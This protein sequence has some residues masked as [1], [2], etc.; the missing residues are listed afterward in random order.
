MSASDAISNHQQGRLLFSGCDL[1]IP[2]QVRQ[3]QRLRWLHFDQHAIQACIDLDH[4]HQ[5][6]IP[7]AEA[8]VLAAALKPGANRLLNLGCG[9]GS[10][11]RYFQHYLPS[12]QITS[13][14]A[15]RLIIDLAQRWFQLPDDLELF[16]T[17]AETFLRQNR[18][19]FELI[20]CDLHIGEGHADCLDQAEF[21]RQLKHAMAPGGILVCNLLP[22]DNDQLLR[23]LLPLR[24]AFPHLL[25]L[26][27]ENKHNC[28]IFG[29]DQPPPNDLQIVESASRWDQRC[30]SQLLHYSNSLIRLPV[31]L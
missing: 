4:P 14:E 16:N 24:Q 22:V 31:A 12:L 7:Y 9:A 13:V 19:R 15:S 23:W 26:P 10:F 2:I 30:G 6:T 27:L 1:G 18:Q 5:L 11:E 29:F 28:L 17:T 21:Y 25:L 8:M 20:F 3:W